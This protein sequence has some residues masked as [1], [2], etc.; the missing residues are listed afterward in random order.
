M[1]CVKYRLLGMTSKIREGS[2]LTW[3]QYDVHWK[4]KRIGVNELLHFKGVIV[5]WSRISMSHLDSGLNSYI[6]TVR[7]FFLLFL[8]FIYFSLKIAVKETCSHNCFKQNRRALFIMYQTIHL[9]FLLLP[10]VAFTR[11]PFQSSS[12]CHQTRI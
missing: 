8:L 7:G 9:S 4:N 6:F 12:L 11:S 5:D 3:H 2:G 1:K 10:D